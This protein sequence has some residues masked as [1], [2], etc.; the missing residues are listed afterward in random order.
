MPYL[1]AFRKEQID[2]G[3]Y[4]SHPGE[5]NYAITR[6]LINYWNIYGEKLGYRAIS[7]ISSSCT[8]ALAEFRRRVIVP[9]E[10]NKILENGDVYDKL[11]PANREIYDGI[12]GK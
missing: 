2:E 11:S 3:D 6:L 7:D 1:T 4:A 9:Y 8:E 10:K 12:Y 5:L